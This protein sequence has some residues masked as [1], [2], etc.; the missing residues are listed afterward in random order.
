MS[1]SEGSS[2]N[3]LTAGAWGSAIAISVAN[4][5]QTHD[6]V[7][8]MTLVDAIGLTTLALMLIWFLWK[9]SPGPGV[10]S[11]LNAPTHENTAKSL[12]FRLGKALN[13]ILN[14]RRRR[15]VVGDDAG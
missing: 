13:R 12:P 4:Y 14:G 2:G 11:P 5:W 6:R 9:R 7:P 10:L 3:K 1:D 8:P 15:P